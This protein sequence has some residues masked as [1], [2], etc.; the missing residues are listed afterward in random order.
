MGFKESLDKYLT[1]EP[2]DGGFNNWLENV[3]NGFSDEFWEKNGEWLDGW[4]S[5]DK[6]NDYFISIFELELSVKES[7]LLIEKQINNK[8]FSYE[9]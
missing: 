9:E 6:G 1:S 4:S 8:E 2:Y 3:Y 5:T 7:I